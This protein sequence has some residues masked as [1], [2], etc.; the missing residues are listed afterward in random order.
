MAARSR[1]SPEVVL[2]LSELQNLSRQESIAS[3][4]NKG[5]EA[6]KYVDEEAALLRDSEL[7]WA[8]ERVR[9]ER[10]VSRQLRGLREASQHIKR[11]IYR[12]T[13]DEG[14][15]D[16]PTFALAAE[17]QKRMEALQQDLGS[18][19]TS[20]RADFE[21]TVFEERALSR[22][23]E[24]QAERFNGWA[25]ADAAEDEETARRARI[26]AK[27]RQSAV[28][29]K[30][31]ERGSDAG[32]RR[33][34]EPR[35]EKRRDDLRG[36]IRA[37]DDAV[38]ELVYGYVY[39]PLRRANELTRCRQVARG[40][41]PSGR[42]HPTEH[43]F[44]LAAWTQAVGVGADL[45]ASDLSPAWQRLLRALCE[46]CTTAVPSRSGAEVEIHARWWALHLRR[47]EQKRGLVLAW[48]NEQRPEVSQLPSR[49]G[50]ETQRR[51]HS[52]NLFSRPFLLSQDA[53]A[54]VTTSPDAPSDGSAHT[55]DDGATAAK[56][57][58][59]LAVEEWRSRRRSEAELAAA[60][61]E[62]AKREAAEVELRLRR[63]QRAK[64]EAV[65]LFKLEKE[66]RQQLEAQIK[67][68]LQGQAKT[69]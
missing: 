38:R 50:M 4:L 45:P 8:R 24:E 1:P 20:M 27:R 41:G 56:E 60:G 39:S 29:H 6:S 42:W 23:V 9:D 63:G 51:P 46:K 55:G 2:W 28:A 40:G 67:H 43:S 44:F 26:D 7:E 54:A 64:K 66:Q 31:S 36:D 15:G 13:S 16:S 11:V 53:P 14:D 25:A 57:A 33:K 37:I 52:S 48:R 17:L 3:K 18:F 12:I 65:A 21:K 61:D 32:P 68:V 10:R 49:R 5:L 22:E 35:P 34:G 59:R 62:H 69:M 19:K 30:E 58:K 47:L